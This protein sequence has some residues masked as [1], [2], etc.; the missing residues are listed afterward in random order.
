MPNCHVELVNHVLIPF[1]FAL[2]TSYI[3]LILVE[4]AEMIANEDSGVEYCY[5]K[6]GVPSGEA[7][8]PP[9]EW[10]SEA[11]LRPGLY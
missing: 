10:F 2:V 5:E 7:N 11:V 6:Q 3:Q 8:P 4:E 1:G 9:R